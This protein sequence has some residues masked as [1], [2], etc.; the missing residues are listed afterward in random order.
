MFCA[1]A[2]TISGTTSDGVSWQKGYMPANR[3]WGPIAHNGSVFCTVAGGTNYAATSTDG[4]SWTEHSMA[5]SGNW[6]GLAYG[7]GLFVAVAFS[8]GSACQTSPDGITWTTRSTPGL[9]YYDV[10]R[11]GSYFIAIATGSSGAFSADGI[12]W[13]AFAMPYSTL[14][15][16]VVAFKG[17]ALA[18][19]E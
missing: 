19:T 2:Q 7:A 17:I 18:C 4:L 11:V 13:T 6:Q 5:G 3:A 1:V 16:S 12:T 10:A 14:W 8:G 15:K 9:N